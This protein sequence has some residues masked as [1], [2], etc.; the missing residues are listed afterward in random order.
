MTNPP[1]G[2]YVATSSGTGMRVDYTY[3][4][5]GMRKTKTVTTGTLAS[6]PRDGLHWD[7]DGVLRYYEDGYL[8]RVGLIWEDG[9]YYY[10]KSD[11]TAV[12]NQAYWITHNNG[13]MPNLQYTF[14]EYGWLVNPSA[15]EDF[16]IKMADNQKASK[17]RF[18][19]WVV[20]DENATSVTYVYTYNGGQLT[21]MIADDDT[22]IFAYDGAGKPMAVTWNGTTYLYLTNIQGDVIAILDTEGNIVVQYTY[23][24]WGNILTTTGTLAESLGVINP[25][26][27]RG[28]VYDQETGLYYLQSRYYNPTIGRFINADALVSTGQ[29]L[30]GN[31][32]FAYCGN[33]PTNCFDSSGTICC[34]LFGDNHLFTP[35]SLMIKDGGGGGGASFLVGLAANDNR[36]CTL[37]TQISK[38]T[39]KGSIADF[40]ER[41]FALEAECKMYGEYDTIIEAGAELT[42][43]EGSYDFNGFDLTSKIG[44][45]EASAAIKINGVEA[46]AY[47]ALWSP[48]ASF[49]ICGKRITIEIPLCSIGLMFGLDMDGDFSL[50]VPGGG[51]RISWGDE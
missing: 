28:Y 22:L 34:T 38:S 26:T 39:N 46:G 36:S 24:A 21:Q 41:V 20:D 5:N 32:M 9:H 27:Y 15:E 18:F 14:N 17:E 33:N 51:L 31:N 30:L 8:K 25:L 35:T 48:S 16:E 44:T 19:D 11:G 37:S 10:I 42:I 43:L 40:T 45:A 12:R 6:V 29:G 50:V 49:T 3:D 2:S 4:A 1:D 7:E 13:Y 23:D 47:A